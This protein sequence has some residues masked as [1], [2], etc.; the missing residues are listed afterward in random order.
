M[1]GKGVTVM[2][3]AGTIRPTETTTTAPV[4]AATT[5]PDGQVPEG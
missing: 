1:D 4:A 2:D 5:T 3:P